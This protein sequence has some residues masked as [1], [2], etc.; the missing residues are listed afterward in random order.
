MPVTR[1][2]VMER[3]RQLV[4]LGGLSVALFAACGQTETAG[5][6]GPPDPLD[7]VD[8]WE[9][10]RPREPLPLSIGFPGLTPDSVVVEV[11]RRWGLR[12]YGALVY[13]R[14]T[15]LSGHTGR[16]PAD[17]SLDVIE[18]ARTNAADQLHQLLC[19][20]PDRARSMLEAGADEE[21]DA[22]LR[23]V[24]SQFRFAGEERETVADE[25]ILYG[26]YA[27]GAADTVRSLLEASPG[28]LSS[29]EPGMVVRGPEGR[30]RLVVPQ[31]EN[32]AYR[33]PR[34]HPSLSGMDRDALLEAMRDLQDHGLRDCPENPGRRR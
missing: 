8:R 32:P 4:V 11:L 18:E 2:R 26:V 22:P 19:R 30:E 27:V 3:K 20:T 9:R 10:E 21:S 15:G 17:A 14:G 7:R 28:R 25:P 1:E 16:D 5:E 12:P 13:L 33:Q 6:T 23:S 29:V 34:D 24:L 31:P